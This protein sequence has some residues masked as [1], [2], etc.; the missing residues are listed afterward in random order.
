MS[1]GDE[2]ELKP[3]APKNGRRPNILMLFSDEH[4]ARMSGFMGDRIV[5]TPN[6]DRLASQ[7]VVFDNA[8]CNSPLCSPS[9]QSFMAGLYCHHAD[10]WNNTA[11]M[12]EDT[13]TWAHMLSLAGYE[14]SLVGKMHFNGYQRMYGFDRRPVLEA[15]DAGESFYSY[16]ARTSHLWTDPLPYSSS[17]VRSD[18][19]QSL[20]RAGPD[21]PQRLP[22]FQ[23]DL[24]ILD[25]TLKMLRE[26]ATEPD[27][28]PWAICSSFVLPHPPL[29]GRADIVER[30]RGKGDLPVNYKGEGRDV[31]DRYIQY[32][33]GN[34]YEA[35]EEA[36][37]HGREVY[38]SL[39][40][41]FDEY[42]GRILDCLRTCM[43]TLTQE[44]A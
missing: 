31:C 7:G 9:R 28:Q 5:Q 41:E 32:W 8:Y 22:I 44:P 13:V 10:I 24:E 29:R 15:N 2:V 40:T 34:M 26:K 18:P 16:G 25:V 1:L 42:A 19:T 27:S 12:P 38:F 33:Y 11:S 20:L 43:K 30:Y 4:N 36:I 6:L 35:S 14:T 39:I 37:R 17:R 3:Q 23:K 21:T